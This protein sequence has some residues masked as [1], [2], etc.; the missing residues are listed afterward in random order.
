MVLVTLNLELVSVI[1][2]SRRLFLTPPS[3][4][5]LIDLVERGIN[6]E[7][8]VFPP[9]LTRPTFKA[10]YNLGIDNIVWKT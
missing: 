7:L 8:L 3:E 9:A 4:L 1:Y 6:C 10:V 5:S 2:K